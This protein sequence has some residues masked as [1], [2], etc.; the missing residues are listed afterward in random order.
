MRL[1]ELVRMLLIMRTQTCAQLSHNLTQRGVLNRKS[2]SSSP[3]SG[4]TGSDEIDNNQWAGGRPL[5]VLR[6]QKNER[7]KQLYLI[8][9][10]KN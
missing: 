2:G 10:L 9:P 7:N 1:R 6:N 8:H 5:S 4:G 3:S